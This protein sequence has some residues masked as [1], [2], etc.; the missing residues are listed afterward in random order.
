MDDHTIYIRPGDN[1]GAIVAR[2]SRLTPGRAIVVFENGAAESINRVGLQLIERQATRNR[3][4][5]ALVTD[6]PDLADEA[7]ELGLPTFASVEAARRHSWRSTAK[8]SIARQGVDLSALP[9]APID[10]DDALEMRRRTLAA[11][12][13][14]HWLWWA[15]SVA[16][17]IFA[18]AVVAGVAL[19]LW[20]S[21]HVRLS[22]IS[23]PV[24]AVITL[25]VDPAA[26]EVDEE[27]GV[28]PA[29]YLPVEV[30]N[31][32]QITTTGAKDI[33]D[34][35]A[36]GDVVFTNLLPQPVT[37]PKGTIVRTNA[38]APV[39]FATT[40]DVVAPPNGQVTAPVEALDKGPVG[41]V[42]AGVISRIDGALALQLRVANP[43]PTQ[44][45]AARQV[46]AVTQ[47]DRDRLQAALLEQLQSQALERMMAELQP[48][49]FLVTS[50]LRLVEVLDVTYDRFVGEQADVLGM[51][52][53]VRMQAVAVDE[54]PARR[55]ALAALERQ[56]LP[57]YTLI[58]SSVA[59][60]RRSN[61]IDVDENGRM[62]FRMAVN[63][64][65]T[66]RLDLD[67]AMRAAR[68]QPL[69]RA[70]AI[71]ADQLPLEQPPEIQVSPSWFPYMPFL[72]VRTTVE[73][74]TIDQ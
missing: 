50:S 5:L 25:V 8:R 52:M 1:A 3:L 46:R 54:A 15:V 63:G 59:T 44:G 16:I 22:P 34:A 67:A 66:A 42:A 13:R 58:P 53:R 73:L 49:E 37:I 24:S 33:P 60:P 45:G 30:E 41:N 4:D 21:A 38:G 31:Q 26:Q 68:L 65:M 14:R 72:S 62:T 61:T 39:R 19:L 48:T 40:A 7:R 23:R 27:A 69:T 64:A 29:R 9:D 2:L 43:Q 71:L 51:Q 35:P 28:V 32:A 17:F 47:A 55:L 36:R 18:I 56:V 57:G 10:P 70:R 12:R 11:R 6:S 20:P 74:V